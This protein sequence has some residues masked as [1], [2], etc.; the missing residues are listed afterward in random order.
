MCAFQ[1]L[2]VRSESEEGN[3]WHTT[4][5]GPHLQAFETA[6]RSVQLLFKTTRP[7]VQAAE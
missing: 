3:N 1:G 6:A 4:Y 7:S 2:E 5:T